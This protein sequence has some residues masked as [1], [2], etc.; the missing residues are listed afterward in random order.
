VADT[1]GSAILYKAHVRFET[2]LDH[3]ISDSATV[4]FGIRQVTSDHRQVASLFKIKWPADSYSSRSMGAR[5]VSAADVEKA[6]CGSA[7]REGHGFEYDSP[8]GRIDRDELFN[9]TD[10]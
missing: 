7:L 8:E 2:E 6:G 4:S 5:Y 9:K 3:E 10:D 1:I